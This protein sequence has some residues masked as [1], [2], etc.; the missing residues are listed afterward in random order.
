MDGL[1]HWDFNPGL[2]VAE[3]VRRHFGST[4]HYSPSPSSKEFF[5]AVTFSSAS[6]PLSISSVGLALQCSI[7]GSAAGFNVTQIGDRQ[8]WF[9]IAS[10]K[11]GH[12]I[13]RLR[14]R[15]WPDFICRFNL[16]GHH[17][18]ANSRFSSDW[19]ADHQLPE[20]VSRTPMAIKSTLSF[21]QSRA[22]SDVA[23]SSEL[24]K[25][26]IPMMFSR[27]CDNDPPV[28][29]SVPMTGLVSGEPSLRNKPLCQPDSV[30]HE[31]Q[32]KFGSFDRSGLMRRRNQSAN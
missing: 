4:V 1:L 18:L 8:F 29:S 24:S 23:A 31:S 27:P 10:N 30:V 9:S 6:F 17:Q 28:S 19:H 5:L 3:Q 20:I 12:F 22:G 26:A 21:L 7:G 32:L 13:Y 25:F 2:A 11:V 15:I 14:D 16:Y